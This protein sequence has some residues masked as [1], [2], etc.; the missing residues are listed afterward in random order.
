M[1]MP[2]LWLIS[3]DSCP[4]SAENTSTSTRYYPVLQINIFYL[5]AYFF[6]LIHK[7]VRV[8][9][10]EIYDQLLLEIHHAS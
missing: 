1:N 5:V 8:I 6:V 9:K 10:K 2:G 7:H 4:G 3:S